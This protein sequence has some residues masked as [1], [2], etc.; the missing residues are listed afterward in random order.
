MD[1]TTTTT[2]SQRKNNLCRRVRVEKEKRAKAAESQ[3]DLHII[4]RI[5]FAHME[6]FLEIYIHVDLL[7]LDST[8]RYLLD[9]ASMCTNTYT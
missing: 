2:L 9:L 4:R 1:G 6:E 5:T 7:D 8:C 3:A